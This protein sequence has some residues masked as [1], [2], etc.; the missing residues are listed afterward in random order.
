MSHSVLTLLLGLSSAAAVPAQPAFAAT[1]QAVDPVGDWI[2]YLDVGSPLRVALHVK[3]TGDKLTATADSLD[4]DAFDIA[5]QAITAEGGRL[6]FEVQSIQGRYAGTWDAAKQSYVG[7]WTQGG[8]ML[9]LEFTRGKFP[10]PEAG[11]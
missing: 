7:T 11:K 8:R 1:T 2:G 3:R 6:N 4:E 5:V 10:S 9:P